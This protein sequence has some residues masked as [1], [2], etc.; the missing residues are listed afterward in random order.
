MLSMPKDLSLENPLVVIG[1]EDVVMGFGALGF[2]VYGLKRQ[3]EFNLVLEE[4]LPRCAI[5]L[6]EDKFYSA[7]KD[8]LD[9][10][11]NL[12]FPVFIPFSKDTKPDLL[13]NIIK[14]I[15][16]KATGAL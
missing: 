10:Y 5:C 14:D 7:L 13:N 4:I 15:Q 2:K 9:D 1:D 16:I 8:R 6:V 12:A 11:R 3:E